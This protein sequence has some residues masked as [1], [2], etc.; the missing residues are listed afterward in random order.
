MRSE[1]FLDAT[2]SGICSRSLEP[3]GRGG[4]EAAVAD[5]RAARTGT[6]QPQNMQ[7]FTVCFAM[8]YVAGEDHTIDRPAESRLLE[9]LCAE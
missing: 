5:R 3:S 1:Y 6:A 2:S 8:D 4:F 7:A 9:R